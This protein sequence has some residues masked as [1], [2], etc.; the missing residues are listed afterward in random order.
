VNRIGGQKGRCGAGAAAEVFRYGPHSGEEPP[1]SGTRGSGTVF[2]SRCTMECVYCQNYPWSQEGRGDRYSVE[3][4]TLALKSLRRAG[5]HNWNL[6][7]PAPW[8]PFIR[9]ALEK[10]GNDDISLPVVYNTSGFE[11]VNT[12]RLF[13]DLVDVYLA[14]LRYSR[15]ESAVQLS[16]VAGYVETARRALLEMWAQKGALELDAD[17]IAVRG[18]ICRLLILPGRAEEAVENLEWLA[19]AVGA[20]IAVSVMAQ[21]VPAHKAAMFTGLDRKITAEEYGMVLE[22]MEQFGFTSGWIQDVDKATD[23]ALLGFEMVAGAG[24]RIYQP[25][26]E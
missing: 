22:A 17:G 15:N 20:E 2:F 4:L 21:Y 9:E 11:R 26:I 13:G 24:S 19:E 10:A 14:D 25:A 12:V 5:C 8:L 1:I 6:V 23:K 18:T 16:G 3:D 7:S